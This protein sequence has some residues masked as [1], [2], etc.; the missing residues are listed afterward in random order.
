[1]LINLNLAT[2][3]SIRIVGIIVTSDMH[4]N[5]K[6]YETLVIHMQNIYKIKINSLYNL[7]I[8]LLE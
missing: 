5:K 2:S 7:I 4:H 8:I 6:I 1:M 3:I